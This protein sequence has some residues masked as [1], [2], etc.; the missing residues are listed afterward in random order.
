MPP[1]GKGGRGRGRGRGGQGPQPFQARPAA[2]QAQYVP[3]AHPL[4]APPP[5]LGGPFPPAGPGAPPGPWAQQGPRPQ[6]PAAIPQGHV[7]QAT[8][9]AVP[10]QP[11]PGP[12]PAG[13]FP[14][15]GAPGRS[16]VPSQ[17]A[18]SLVASSTLASSGYHAGE[19]SSGGAAGG[20]TTAGTVASMASGSSG[21]AAE[22]I[23]GSFQ[24]LQLVPKLGQMP[25]RP[26]A[27]GTRGTK[28]SV[29]VNHFRVALDPRTE[30]HQYDVSIVKRDSRAEQRDGP[31]KAPSRG[32]CRDLYN[33]I[34]SRY[35]SPAGLPDGAPHL[36]GFVTVY[37]AQKNLYANGR[38][39]IDP[40]VFRAV[41]LPEEEMAGSPPPGE[42]PRRPRLYDVTIKYTQPV[43]KYKLGQFLASRVADEP[44]DVINALDLVLREK[45][46]NMF[47][48]AA[49]A[50]FHQNAFGRNPFNLTGGIEAFRGFFQSMRPSQLGDGRN[51]DPNRPIEGL[52]L[53]V[54]MSTTSFVKAIPVIDWL[55]DFL[56]RGWREGQPLSPRDL[57]RVKRQLR[58]LKVDTLHIRRRS[59]ITGI[60]DQPANRLSFMRTVD[61]QE[62]RTGIVEYFQQQYNWRLKFPNMQCLETG[63]D[64]NRKNWLPMELCIIAPNQRYPKKLTGQQMSNM[65]TAAKQRP[66]ER[67][68]DI[69][70]TVQ[71]NNYSGDEYAQSFGI[72]VDPRMMQVAARQ[73]QPP[74]IS[75]RDP[76][77]RATQ[78]AP[79]MGSW[80]MR[81][82]KVVEGA[83]V[84]RW[85]CLNL[86][87]EDRVDVAMADSF[88]KALARM[89][90]TTGLAMSET[91]F[92][93]CMNVLPTSQA[94]DAIL[95]KAYERAVA[96]PRQ[97]RRAAPID[98]IL[99]ILPTNNTI[100][101]EL[102]RIAEL[103]VG[104]V[105]QCVL[106]KHIGA[107]KPQYMANVAL[108]INPKCGGRNTWLMDASR[109]MLPIV[110][111]RPTILFGADV[112]HPSPGDDT[113]SIAAVVASQDWP[114]ISAYRGLVRS[115][116]G[117]EEIIRELHKEV[118]T[119]SPRKGMAQEL[120]E[121][122]RDRNRGVL[123]E[124]IIFY[125]DGVSDGEFDAVRDNE[126]YE[127]RKACKA[128]N[129]A[130]NP[131]ITFIV[132]QKRHHTRMF[133]AVRGQEDSSGNVMPGTVIDQEIC[134]PFQFDFFLV[135]HA[136]IQG[137][138][139]PAKYVVLWDENNFSANDLQG[140][141]NDLCY[142]Y[143]G[144]TRSVSVVPPAY[145]AHKLA[146]RAR[147]YFGPDMSDSG[148][149]AAR[150]AARR[151]G[152]A[153]L[154][155]QEEG[156]AES[157]ASGASAVSRSSRDREEALN[158]RRIPEIKAGVKEVLF[159]I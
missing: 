66:E 101:G 52:T 122:F 42:R 154:A 48:P 140:L 38:L 87:A 78:V 99:C 59:R 111:K 94:V 149:E 93:P 97:P 129:A 89:C 137:V 156:E 84:E 113:P 44:A 31:A 119:H 114:E 123:P 63:M 57:S 147:S 118:S 33:L 35:R 50:F 128:I 80:N 37:D 95:R 69:E 58:M 9:S 88:S 51:G 126:I 96:T 32:V 150:A 139:R 151:L 124:I 102:K 143:A 15:L 148:S 92:L 39:P 104:L 65:L 72:T 13:D 61:G 144:C 46:T 79:R 107:Q 112:T 70:T 14:G 100:Y 22:E 73:M 18:T 91:P 56:G 24:R 21:S 27:T 3:P 45:P 138:S 98:L 53:N 142:T 135:S 134:H 28:I 29:Y 40:V 4:G 152:P 20:G 67:K 2:P 136:G 115:Q 90:N 106:A 75:Y 10:P 159:Y 157:A 16:S 49:R 47:V 130:Y 7:W 81:G 30:I 153:A 26:Q 125:R 43:D 105:T 11:F 131:K 62:V 82:Y 110:S 103:E 41:E 116:P 55:K 120:L 54:D 85:L 109:K 19:S 121:A 158:W 71:H 5:V 77:N 108:N 132:V 83:R 117:K 60:T 74:S 145:Y 64:P 12:P 86:A 76:Q 17:G 133:P 68:R 8:Q 127:L 6:Q 141:T 1:K 146:F 23:A 155:A 25:R 36:G 34:V